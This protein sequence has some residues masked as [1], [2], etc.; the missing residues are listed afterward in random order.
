MASLREETYLVPIKGTKNWM[1][2][3]QGLNDVGYIPGIREGEPGYMSRVVASVDHCIDRWGPMEGGRFRYDRP[4]RCESPKMQRYIELLFQKTHQRPIGRVKAIGLAFARG[5]IAEMKGY[6]VDWAGF[7]M[8]MCR[9]G[10]K[11]TL[12]FESFDDL[13]AKCER[14]EAVWPGGEVSAEGLDDLEGAPDNWEINRNA[15]KFTA[16]STFNLSRWLQPPP[17][18]VVERPLWRVKTP[19]TTPAASVDPSSDSISSDTAYPRHLLNA[20]GPPLPG[21]SLTSYSLCRCHEYSTLQSNLFP[22]ISASQLVRN[23]SWQ[24]T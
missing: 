10:N 4:G 24:L 17:R 8:R 22:T 3:D 11:M 14:G 9:R 21:T 23:V 16:A 18:T 13:K 6:A 5:L 20:T 1:R 19:A 2:R 7:A 15:R 12:P